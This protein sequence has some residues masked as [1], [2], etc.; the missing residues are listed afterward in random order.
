MAAFASAVPSSSNAILR[1]DHVRWGIVGLGDVT[2]VKS[3]PPFYKCA[4]S[5]LVAVMRRTPGAA[6]QWVKSNVP[7]G[8]SCV[9]YDSLDAFLA[10]PDLDAVY[11]ATP[12]GGHLSTA[13]KVAAAGK[14]C[15]IEKPVGRSGAET[16]AIVDAFASRGLCLFTAYVSRAYERTAAVRALLADGAVGDHVSKVTYRLRGSGGAR[17]MDDAE[18]ALPW[19]LDA[20]QSGGGLIMDVGCHVVDRIDF[21]LGPLQSVTGRA[22]NQRSPLQD[23]EDYVELRAEIGPS[24]WAAVPSAGA[25]VDCAWEFA[26]EDPAAPPIDELV[27][28]GPRG[29]LRMAAMSAAAPVEVLD[30]SGAA[31]LR[32]LTFEQPQ[33]TAQRL[34]QS[35]T[36]ELLLVKRRGG[37]AGANGVGGRS[38]VAVD[39]GGGRVV[40]STSGV[41]A[42]ASAA[43]RCPSRGE[44]ALRTSRA[45][46]K[47]L[48]AYYGGRD[49]AYWSRA[50]TWPG[51]SS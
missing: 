21:L 3:G 10:H 12:P 4:G 48:N 33:H 43:T 51:R 35:A 6:A 13:L 38:G 18:S 44:N 50:D 20:R 2:A 47:A 15:Y 49:D 27:I 25:K 36:D 32:T 17:G 11:V 24:D 16:A 28:A 40:F 8:N 1:T 29:S 22:E 39:G 7:A 41:V 14:H 31:V 23:V 26:P 30:A 45:L 5:S 46:D 9:G 37:S 34:I 42:A 19:R